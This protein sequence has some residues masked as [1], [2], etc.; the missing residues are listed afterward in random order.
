MSSDDSSKFLGPPKVPPVTINTPG[1][2][3]AAAEE[4]KKQQPEKSA[5]TS[6]ATPKKLTENVGSATGKIFFKQIETN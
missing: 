2:D 5:S 6:L 1:V 4:K 3:A